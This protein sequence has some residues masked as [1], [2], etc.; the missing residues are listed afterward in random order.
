V[1]YH[2]RADRL[3]IHCPVCREPQRHLPT[4]LARRCMAGQSE[5]ARREQVK[6]ARASQKAWSEKGRVW[7]FGEIRQWCPE[8]A[9]RYGLL[10]RLLD[11]NFI[12]LNLPEEEELLALQAES[13]RPLPCAGEQVRPEAAGPSTVLG[14][15][16][17]VLRRAQQEILVLTKSLQEGRHV[18]DAEKTRFRYYCE[19][20]LI[21]KLLLSPSTVENLTAKEWLE[22]R[23]SH[24]NHV[25][26]VHRPTAE[27]KPATSFGLT[28]NDAALLQLYFSKIRPGNLKDRD[29]PDNQFFVGQSGSGIRSASM[30]VMRLHQ[31]YRLPMVCSEDVRQ[32]A[33]RDVAELPEGPA[34]V[35]RRYLGLAG[36]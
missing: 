13:A 25:I 11:N 18:T 7:D 22:R 8:P 9:G 2:I 36:G 15:C 4:H 21:L 14:D 20:V 30:D 19:A 29:L 34:T 23:P 24:D 1:V 27:G 17:L 32:V 33:A 5:E 16:Q 35:L 10:R 28:E 3:I 31:H 26:V 12:V 6:A